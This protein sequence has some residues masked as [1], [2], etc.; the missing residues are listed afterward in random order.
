MSTTRHNLKFKFTNATTSRTITLTNVRS[1]IATV[2]G[3]QQQLNSLVDFLSAY[4][5]GDYAQDGVTLVTTT[6]TEI[7][8][9]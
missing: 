1:D 5:E 2:E 3:S 8:L 6:E 4:L 7:D 9:G